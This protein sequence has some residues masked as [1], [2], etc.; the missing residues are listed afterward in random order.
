MELHAKLS[1]KR[2]QLTMAHDHE[3]FLGHSSVEQRRLQQQA[4]ELAEESAW[5]FDQVGIAQGWRVVEIGCGPVLR[6]NQD[7]LQNQ[8]VTAEACNITRWN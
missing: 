4:E 3:Y 2:Q 6:E 7:R 1:P 8:L 5:L